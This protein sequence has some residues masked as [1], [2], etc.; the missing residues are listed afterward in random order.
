MALGF[1]IILS[2]L[3]H[4]S[5]RRLASSAVV[6]LIP[7]PGWHSALDKDDSPVSATL[8]G[9]T[10]NRTEI[11]FA[12]E[13]LPAQFRSLPPE[14]LFPQIYNHLI[15]IKLLFAKGAEAGLREDLRVIS[16]V[17]LYAIRHSHDYYAREIIGNYLDEDLLQ[18]VYQQFVKNYPKSDELNVSQILVTTTDKAEEIVANLKSGAKF[19]ATAARFSVRPSASQGGAFGFL[20]REQKMPEFAEI[21]FALDDG[22]I[23]E[24]V[25]PSSVSMSLRPWTGD[26]PSHRAT[27]RSNRRCVPNLPTA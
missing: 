25:K 20:H 9:E 19:S 14:Q 12:L 3:N 15:D 4:P 8:N 13:L 5:A 23:S 18:E 10:I 24:P 16:R 22:E 1:H 2:G 6:A 11:L 7:A 27:V 17:D 21:A 26:F